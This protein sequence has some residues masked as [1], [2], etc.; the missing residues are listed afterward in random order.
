MEPIL[1]HGRHIVVIKRSAPLLLC[2][3]VPAFLHSQTPAGSAISGERISGERIMGVIP[4]F[5]SVSEPEA[6]YVPLR[7]RDK[8][9]LFAKETIDPYTLASAAGGALLSQRHNKAPEYG[10]GIIP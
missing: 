2:L 6:A 1:S 8:W 10:V 9:T 3:V 4:N 7:A 5:Q